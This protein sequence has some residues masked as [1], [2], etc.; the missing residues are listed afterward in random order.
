MSSENQNKVYNLLISKG[1]EFNT[2][3]DTEVI[4]AG[5]LVSIIVIIG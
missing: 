1:I 3:S 2:T 5:Y 4:L